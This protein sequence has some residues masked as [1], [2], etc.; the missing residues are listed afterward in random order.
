M[1]DKK[2]SDCDLILNN[3]ENVFESIDDCF[4]A[5][6]DEKKS[7]MQVLGDIFGIGK[8]IVKL[9][10]NGTKCA[11]KYTPKAVVTVAKYKREVVSVVTEEYGNMQKE[12][13]E[14]AL[15]E[16][17]KRFKNNRSIK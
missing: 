8:S 17:I 10:W 5:A 6:F 13:K 9:G 4:D 14:D 12:M 16:K 11:V 2:Q 1:G 3:V 7:K 15:N